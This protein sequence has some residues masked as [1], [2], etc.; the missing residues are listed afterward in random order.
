MVKDYEF[1][2]SDSASAWGEAVAAGA[3]GSG[4]GATRVDFSA[5]T[6]HYVRFVALTEQNGRPYTSVAELDVVGVRR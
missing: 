2:V 6:G 5:K 3:F 1:Y 4:R